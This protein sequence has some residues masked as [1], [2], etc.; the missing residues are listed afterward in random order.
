[1]HLIVKSAAILFLFIQ[2]ASVSAAEDLKVCAGPLFG[3]DLVFPPAPSPFG[4]A[5]ANKMFKPAGTRPFPALVILLTC[6]GHLAR[7]SFDVWAKA[8]LQ[9]GYRIGRR[10]ANATGCRSSRGKLPPSDQSA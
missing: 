2:S 8:A 7:H 3:E 10:S 9:R 6:A 5:K 1:M 4:S